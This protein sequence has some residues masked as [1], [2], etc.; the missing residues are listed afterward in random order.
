MQQFLIHIVSE[1]KVF[2]GW[3]VKEEFNLDVY[4]HMHYKL[5]TLLADHLNFTL[6]LSLVNDYGWRLENGSFSGLMNSLV[7]GEVEFTTSGALMRFDRMMAAELTVATY[8]VQT[9][10][11][12]KQPPLSAVFNVFFLPFNFTTWIAILLLLMLFTIAIVFFFR[13]TTMIKNIGPHSSLMMTTL[14]TGMLVL[15]AICQQGTSTIMTTTSVRMAFSVLFFTAVFLFTSYSASIVVIL[16]TPSQSIKS[17][18]DLA[19]K[20]TTFSVLDTAHNYVYL[21]ETKIHAVKKIYQNKIIKTKPSDAF[22][23]AKVGMIRVQKEFHAFLVDTSVANDIIAKSWNEQEKCSLTQLN[24]FTLPPLT[25]YIAKKSG[26]KDSIKQQLILQDEVGLKKR[27][28]NQFMPQKPTCDSLN[29]DI[30]IESVSLKE[31]FPIIAFLSCA[32]IVSFIIFV[33]ELMSYN[34]MSIFKS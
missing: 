24:L 13:I 34:M 4:S 20:S 8:R 28:Y 12:F 11:I 5:V 1:P 10:A 27:I 22:T 26:Y 30:I 29:K 15:G 33:L 19:D 16:Q 23:S 3:G 25:L 9:S 21:N 17:I 32:M 31:I 14:D 2:K 18:K 6:D 7:K